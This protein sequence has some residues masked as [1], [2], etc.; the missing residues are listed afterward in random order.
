LTRWNPFG[1]S[2]VTATFWLTAFSGM[3]VAQSALEI[4]KTVVV[5]SSDN[6]RLSGQLFHPKICPNRVYDVAFV[7][8]VRDNRQLWLYDART[9]KLLQITPQKSGGGSE[10]G[11]GD[12]SEDEGFKGYEDELDWC[13]VLHGGKQYFAFVS[14]GGVNNHDIYLGC[15]GSDTYTRLTFD[16]EVDDAPHWSPDGKG[17]VFVSARTGNGDLYFIPDALSFFGKELK[18]EPRDAFQ[19]L[20][21]SPGE[22]MLPVFSPDGRFL[23]YTMRTGGNRKQGLFTIALMDFK[24][25]RRI[26]AFNNQTV[27]SKS[28]PSWSYDGH[29]LAYQISDDLSDRTVDIGVMQIKMDSL[30]H[31][32]EVADLHG[33]GS[34]IAQNVY[35]SSYEGPAWLEGSRALL[36][37]KRESNRFNPLEAVNL[38]KW[39]YGSGDERTFLNTT[40]SIH[41]DVDCLPHDPIVVFAAES[42]ESFQ[43]FA[44]LLGGEDIPEEARDVNPD[45]YDLFRGLPD[46]SR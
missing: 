42:G 21:H 14:A 39:L 13:P 9:R 10:A 22:E 40:S 43:I 16:P 46:V 38:E 41:R 37:P 4:R 11:D 15:V 1:W 33:E 25:N 30:G 34:K 7:R 6:P 8:Q 44:S 45:T 32:V 5:V 24:E 28:H 2:G 26:M 35:P 20:T 3:A 19:R 36:Y 12:E 31:L 18:R 27:T 23:A 17:L 29:F